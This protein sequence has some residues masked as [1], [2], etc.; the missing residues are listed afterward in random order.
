M[1]DGKMKALW[2]KLRHTDG[3]IPWTVLDEFADALVN[4]PV[5]WK[6]L[7][8]RYNELALTTENHSG[9]ELLYIPAIF[10]KAAPKLSNEAKS[11]MFPFLVEKLCEAGFDDDDLL[12]EVCS[13]A[14]GSMGTVIV[15][16]V[17]DF[18]LKEENTY[19]AWVF[20]WGLLRLAK[21]ADDGLRRRVVDFC[22]DFLKKA[23]DGEISLMDAECAA[24]ILSNLGCSDHVELLKHLSIKSKGTHSSVEYKASAEILA[25]KQEP[26]DIKEMWEESV[27]EWLPSRWK[28]YKDWYEKDKTAEAAEEGYDDDHDYEEKDYFQHQKSRKIVWRF[29]RSP[30]AAKNF[31]DCYDDVSFLTGNLLDYAWMYENTDVPQLNDRVLEEV[32]FAL[33]PRKIVGGRELFEKIP[34]ITVTFLQWLAKQDILPD[35]WELADKVNDWSE[36]I[37]TAGMNPANWGPGKAFS[38]KAEA[39]GVDTTDQGAMQRYMAKYNRTML[40]L[41]DETENASDSWPEHRPPIPISDIPAK[42]GRNELCPCGSGKKYK[43][44]CG[45]FNAAI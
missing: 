3:P 35:G 7:A 25:G 19:G 16:T 14:C 17:I 39:A 27:E 28:M 33:F 5:I 32:L 18:I 37:I 26:C 38:M 36:E 45:S 21:R 34:T 8:K 24:D 44:C 23:D 9:Y 29:L 10:A 11:E 20:L 22:V 1:D 4:D 12:L 6:Q 42:T 13:A 43:K 41:R 40:R 31:S 15:P 30:D 2:S